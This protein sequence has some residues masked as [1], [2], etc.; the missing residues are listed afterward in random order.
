M[1]LLIITGSMGAGK[2]AVLAEASDILKLRNLVHA[3]IDVDSL[4]LGHLPSEANN[5][6]VMY[7]NLRSVCNNY[8]AR[9]IQRFLFALAIE[10]RAQLELCREITSATD[11][12]ICRLTVSVGVMQHR[13]KTRESGVL[14]QE[15]VARV[16]KLN[17]ILD[18][19]QL[20]DFTVSNENRLLNEVA[21]EMLNK[22]GW[23]S[24]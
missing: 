19:A 18:A 2:S 22:A 11:T 17:A 16:E 3:A 9:G 1:E 8:A 13:V 14:Q 5:D 12:I 24:N 4:F 23:I 20:E 10:N 6:D 21:L 15:F 7:D